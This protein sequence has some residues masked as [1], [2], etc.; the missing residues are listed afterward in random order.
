[1]KWSRSTVA[2]IEADQRD[3]KV[4]EWFALLHL[5]GV[6]G[7]DLIPKHLVRLT[8]EVGFHS[9]ALKRSLRGLPTKGINQNRYVQRDDEPGEAEQKAARALGMTVVDLLELSRAKWGLSLSAERE[10]RLVREL[11]RKKPQP[12]RTP[13]S[14]QAV[15]GRLTRSLIDELRETHSSRGTH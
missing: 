4:T 11:K 13:R 1:M 15:R 3:L 12:P 5:L 10:R 9:T 14:V 6:G 8:P 2:K 7:S